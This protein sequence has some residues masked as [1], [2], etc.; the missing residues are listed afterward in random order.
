MSLQILG[1]RFLMCPDRSKGEWHH[2]AVVGEKVAY[3]WTDC[4]D[5]S[6]EQYSAFMGVTKQQEPA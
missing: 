6:D 1:F 5:M 3:G 2:P 4:T